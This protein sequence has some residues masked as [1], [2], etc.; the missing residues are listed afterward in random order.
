MRI[1]VL[2][3]T[4]C[5]ALSLHAQE[6]VIPSTVPMTNTIPEY[7]RPK[8]TTWLKNQPGDQ[9][10]FWT[11]SFQKDN[12][13]VVLGITAATG[14]LIAADQ[15][16]FERT[17]KIGDQTRI[18][19]EGQQKT[20][21]KTKIPGFNY[22]VRLN[23]P[24]DL[25]TA[26]YFLGDGITHFTIA[27]SFL[28]YGLVKDNNR[29][30]QTSS[31]LLEGIL[32][33]GIVVQVLKHTTGREN[34]NTLTAPGGKWRFFPNQ[35]DYAKNVAKYDAFPS[36]HLATAMVTVTVTSMNYPEYR[37]IRPVGY[38]LM[39]G[40]AFQMVNN[41]VHW[42]SDY[43]LAIG[44][45][46]LFGKIAVERGRP[47]KLQTAHTPF[48][49]VSPTHTEHGWGIMAQHRFG[50]NKKVRFNREKELL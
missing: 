32:A 48:W 20:F 15:Y 25:G 3:S 29:A 39:G 35:K 33:T 24:H 38:T 10:A 28:T 45:G 7:A 2:L 6:G 26:L 14:L 49:I 23:G 19:H 5:M 46:Y 27:G 17:Y 12:L 50:L 41:G 40:L 22:T 42:Y 13:P 31:Q 47:K 43:P 30:L 9:K 21:A 34:P 44:M 37:W 18:S 1:L 36:G 11:R 8:L 4:F 16:L